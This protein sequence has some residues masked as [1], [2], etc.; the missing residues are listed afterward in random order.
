MC[1]ASRMFCGSE[2]PPPASSSTPLTWI[3]SSSGRSVMCSLRCCRLC[4][5]L[6]QLKPD[7]S[8]SFICSFI[9]H[10]TLKDWPGNRPQSSW[11]DTVNILASSWSRLGRGKCSM[12]NALRVKVS[13][14]LAS[15]GRALYLLLCFTIFSPAP[16]CCWSEWSGVNPP[17]CQPSRNVLR[18]GISTTGIVEYPF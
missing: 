8:A 14:L 3:T 15:G 11:Q 16:L 1:P 6:A 7:G 17:S 2:C 13:F 10:L 12:R 18:V 4:S 5:L 9:S